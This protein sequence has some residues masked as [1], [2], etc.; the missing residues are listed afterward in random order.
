MIRFIA[1][2]VAGGLILYFWGEDLKKLAKTKTGEVRT[3]AVD[4]LKS[5]QQ[6]ADGVLD[7]AKEQVDSTLEAGQA[8][9]RPHR[10]R[11]G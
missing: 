3:M 5:V 8:A 1:G 10:I 2:V 4:A 9:L 11:V 6:T 7:S